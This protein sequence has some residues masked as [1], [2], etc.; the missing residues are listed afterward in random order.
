MSRI[1]GQTK[2]RC[3][4]LFMFLGRKNRTSCHSQRV[5]FDAIKPSLLLVFLSI[6]RILLPLQC[7]Y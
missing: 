6:E 7:Q 1:W 4:H 2:L 3:N 5:A